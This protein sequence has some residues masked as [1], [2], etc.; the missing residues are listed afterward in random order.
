MSFFSSIRPAQC[1]ICF[2][3]L[4]K[5]RSE[6]W[7]AT[8]SI[9]LK[10][11]ETEKTQ[12]SQQFCFVAKTIWNFKDNRKSS[13]G[14]KNL[15]SWSIMIFFCKFSFVLLYQILGET[16]QPRIVSQLLPKILRW[17]IKIEF[18]WCN[19]L[20]SMSI[21][22]VASEENFH[23]NNQFGSHNSITMIL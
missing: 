9:I 16:T 23:R 12:K 13:A 19:K 6:K 14:G 15:F 1:V 18:Y 20:F 7:G 22:S 3:N 17:N 21:S 8:P 5:I 11:F 4:G 2:E 10:N